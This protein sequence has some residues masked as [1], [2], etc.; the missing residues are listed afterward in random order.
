LLSL[1]VVLCAELLTLF[2]FSSGTFDVLSLDGPLV[3][4][5]VFA[6]T[7]LITGVVLATRAGRGRLGGMAFLPL[8]MLWLVVVTPVAVLGTVMLVEGPAIVLN[9]SRDLFEILAA[10]LAIA[11]ACFALCVPFLLLAA[12]S[13]TYRERFRAAFG[14]G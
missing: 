3:V 13:A 1:L 14:Q 8:L 4:L 10:S 12:F 11:A 2:C 7:L 6:S 5:P 9:N